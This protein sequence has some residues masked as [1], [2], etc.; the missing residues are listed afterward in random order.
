MAR[1]EIVSVRVT[2]AQK[3]DLAR[4]GRPSQVLRTLIDQALAASPD[5]PDSSGDHCVWGDGSTGQTWPPAATH[6]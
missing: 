5:R 2:A 6:V 3:A 1:D 4:L